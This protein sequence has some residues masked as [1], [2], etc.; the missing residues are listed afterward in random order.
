VNIWFFALKLLVLL[1]LG[2]VL[3]GGGGLERLARDPV[4]FMWLVVVTVFLLL[5][6]GPRGSNPVLQALFTWSWL[7]ALIALAILYANFEI[8]A[9]AFIIRRLC[10]MKIGDYEF[11]RPVCRFFGA[12]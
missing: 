1:V 12:R 10:G 9:K 2:S 5:S 7:I 3:L 6:L 4:T 11:V 8:D